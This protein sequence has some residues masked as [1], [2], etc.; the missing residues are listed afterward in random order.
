MSLIQ[1][2][3]FRTW[4]TKLFKMPRFEMP[5]FQMGTTVTVASE[6]KQTFPHFLNSLCLHIALLSVLTNIGAVVFGAIEFGVAARNKPI[7][8]KMG[9]CYYLQVSL[10]PS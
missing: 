1:L 10:H 9:V 6:L 7:S 4:E 3:K 5:H 2:L 8:Y